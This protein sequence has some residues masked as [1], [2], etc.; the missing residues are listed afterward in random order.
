MIAAL[1]LSLVV[2]LGG[3]GGGSHGAKDAVFSRADTATVAPTPTNTM[4]AQPT[5]T[6]L[7]TG[8]PLPTNTLLPTNTTIPNGPRPGGSDPG[9][10]FFSCFSWG[11]L[12]GSIG[13]GLVDWLVGGVTGFVTPLSGVLTGVVRVDQWP[14]LASF[15]GFMVS[16]GQGV[17]GGLAMLGAL[18]YYRSLASG[19]GEGSGGSG[20]IILTRT[21]ESALLLFGLSWGIDKLFTLIQAIT[22]EVGGYSGLSGGDLL[23]GIISIFT[24]ALVNPLLLVVGVLAVVVFMLLLLVKLGSVAVLAWLYAVAPLCAS[25]WALGAGVMSTWLRNFVAVA[26]WGVGWAIWL[27]VGAQVLLDYSLD[28]TLKPFLALALLLIGYGVPR[29]VDTLLSAAMARASGAYAI[30]GAAI[31]GTMMAASGGMNAVR[32]RVGAAVDRMF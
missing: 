30:A 7:N 10:C 19:T 29:L 16:V 18:R 31:A 24:S 3:L 27:K 23:I 20:L 32:N 8:T 5:N 13:S 11:D 14:T 4:T 21:M 1:A 2:F 22:D 15:F 28:A 26:L 6:A 12:L 17:A 9:W 25:T